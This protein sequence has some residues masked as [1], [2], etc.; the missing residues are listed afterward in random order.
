MQ[1]SPLNGQVSRSIEAHSW[2]AKEWLLIDRA[3]VT[4][5]GVDLAKFTPDNTR[6]GQ[7]SCVEHRCLCCCTRPQIDPT[8][9]RPAVVILGIRV[10]CRFAHL[11]PSLVRQGTCPQGYGDRLAAGH[12][13]SSQEPSQRMLKERKAWPDN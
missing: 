8:R 11:Q 2:K 12:D 5:E 6:S 1:R 10:I 4:E 7:S 13:K 3:S 9:A